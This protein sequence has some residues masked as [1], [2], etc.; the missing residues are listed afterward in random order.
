MNRRECE[1]VSAAVVYGGER[2]G[3]DLWRE[4]MKRGYEGVLRRLW[5]EKVKVETVAPA[6][7]GGRKTVKEMECVT[8]VVVVLVDVGTFSW[9]WWGWGWLFYG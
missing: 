8:T 4:W 1:G 6:V 3:V 9:R 2:C 7:D 5:W